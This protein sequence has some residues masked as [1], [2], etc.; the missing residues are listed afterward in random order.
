MKDQ[1]AAPLIT[2]WRIPV[3]PLMRRVESLAW[4][5]LPIKHANDGSTAFRAVFIPVQ[6]MQLLAACFGGQSHRAK[7]NAPLAPLKPLPDQQLHHAA[8]ESHSKGK[9]AHPQA[10]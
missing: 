1:Q 9:R 4:H 7:Q 2:S 3:K 6:T 8:R 10:H 5:Y